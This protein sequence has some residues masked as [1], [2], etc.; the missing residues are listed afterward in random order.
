[1]DLADKVAFI[2]DSKTR[3]GV[4]EVP[5]TD[6]AVEAFS[7]G[8]WPFPSDGNRTG[9]QTEFKKGWGTGPALKSL[10]FRPLSKKRQLDQKCRTNAAFGF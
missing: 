7:P 4:A 8:P 1:M 3:T 10:P 6:I 5:L 9:H 2:D